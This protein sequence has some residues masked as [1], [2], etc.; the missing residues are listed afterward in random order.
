MEKEKKT[1]DWMYASSII[2]LFHS[3]RGI[4]SGIATEWSDATRSEA[5]TALWASQKEN[6]AA[7]V[8]NGAKIGSLINA[9]VYSE[10]IRFYFLLYLVNLYSHFYVEFSV[11]SIP[12][13]RFA[14]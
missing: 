9:S 5:V 3:R 1:R 14:I 13:L 7:R 12:L 10:H 8:K 4:L 11:D 6:L 2:D